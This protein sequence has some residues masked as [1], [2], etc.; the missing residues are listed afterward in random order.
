MSIHGKPS[1]MG[2]VGSAKTG[3]FPDIFVCRILGI[4]T[5]QLPDPTTYLPSP[6]SGATAAGQVGAA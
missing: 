6:A 4:L 3:D 5:V 2:T 1:C